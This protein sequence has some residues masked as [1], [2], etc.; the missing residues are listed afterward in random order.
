MNEY[1]YVLKLV[2]RLHLK[3]NWSEDDNNV[4]KDHFEHL[5]KLKNS[6]Q[7]ILAGKTQNDDKDTF[8]LVI[9]KANSF[10]EAKDIAYN[11]PAVINNI[12]TVELFDYKVA[13]TG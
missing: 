2:K 9:F 12:M 1:L 10:D 3:E 5:V 11:D 6:G 7:L 8:G 13:I 4:I